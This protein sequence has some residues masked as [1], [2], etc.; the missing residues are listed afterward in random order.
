M[1]MPDIP[2]GFEE[3]DEEDMDLDDYEDETED[4]GDGE[5]E[6]FELN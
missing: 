5:E 2:D 4:E 1:S 3:L 6:N